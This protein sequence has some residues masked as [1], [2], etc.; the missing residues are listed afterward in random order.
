MMM[1][2]VCCFH[3]QI[4]NKLK[5]FI[6]F[7]RGQIRQQTSFSVCCHEWVWHV[8][9]DNYCAFKAWKQPTTKKTLAE[10]INNCRRK[11][12]VSQR[13]NGERDVLIRC[14]SVATNI[15]RNRDWIVYWGPEIMFRWTPNT[16]HV[17]CQRANLISHKSITLYN[18]DICSHRLEN[19]LSKAS[20]KKNFK[21]V[22]TST[23]EPNNWRQI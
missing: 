16:G 7:P 14:A 10:M 13:V 6:I 20:A 11:C 8:S 23:L 9:R 21:S 5:N 18:V 3:F 19:D 17:L 4:G 15:S 12:V 22:K 1:R 2:C